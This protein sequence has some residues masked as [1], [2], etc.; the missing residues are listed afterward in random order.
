MQ[1]YPVGLLL[2]PILCLVSVWEFYRKFY[3]ESPT[4]GNMLF[5]VHEARMPKV[6]FKV[7]PKVMPKVI[8]VTKIRG[9]HVTAA[10]ATCIHAV[11]PRGHNQGYG[12]A[13]NML[14]E[15]LPALSVAAA[16]GRRL[17]MPGLRWNYG[18]VDHPMF[19]DM[20]DLGSEEFHEFGVHS[21]GGSNIEAVT[22]SGSCYLNAPKRIPR[23]LSCG[24]KKLD[25]LDALL[26]A[27]TKSLW[28]RMRPTV[29]AREGN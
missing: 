11:C 14:W 21:P 4:R 26:V 15:Y 29:A 10:R 23:V 18:C 6:V 22:D 19:E 17:A 2:C 7:M 25:V 27:S 16:V 24:N 28:S 9:A 13:S 1:P 8:A 12:L 20:F 3:L 5:M